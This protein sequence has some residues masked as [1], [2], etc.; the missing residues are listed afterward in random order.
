M[1]NQ[2]GGRLWAGRNVSDLE[3]MHALTC[4]FQ[5]GITVVEGRWRYYRLETPAG[6]TI[7]W[8]TGGLQQLAFG[9][10][11]AISRTIAC[12]KSNTKGVGHEK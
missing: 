5:N 4:K 7:Q 12:L 9:F 3:G 2:W 10:A 11:I 6:A 8:L 1:V